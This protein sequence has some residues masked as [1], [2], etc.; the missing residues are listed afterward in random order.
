MDIIT[1]IS[2]RKKDAEVKIEHIKKVLQDLEVKKEQYKNELV[3]Q[4]SFKALCEDLLKKEA[5]NSEQNESPVLSESG[6]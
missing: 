3:K 1:E 5:E 2:E 6:Q 4:L